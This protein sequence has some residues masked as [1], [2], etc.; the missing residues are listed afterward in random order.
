M[1]A[2]GGAKNALVVMPDADPRL[3][4]AGVTGSA[5]GAAGQRC[6]AGSL[7]VLVGTTQQQDRARDLIVEAA[8]ALRTGDGADPRTDVCPLVSPAA[9]ERVEAELERA[10]ADGAELVLDGR[11]DGG[12]GGAELGPTIVD[13]PPPDSRAVTEEL[14]GPLL[15]LVRVPDLAAA[16]EQVDASRYGNASVIFT[17]S[18]GAAREYRYGVQAGMV[19]VNVGVAAPVAWFPFAGWK[20]SF[21]G[22]LHANGTDAVDFYTRKKVVTS[23]WS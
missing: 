23:R 10:L 6:L 18:G 9:R 7:A 12:A 11:R 20:D 14:F 15:T 21:D 19:G 22:D 8:R 1:Q 16:I 13:S 3:M 5:F 17:G 4:A 2:L